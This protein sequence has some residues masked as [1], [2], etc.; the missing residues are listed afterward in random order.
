MDSDQIDG[1]A[2]ALGSTVGGITVAAP[3]L[4][5]GARLAD[6]YT[7]LAVV[8]SVGI[9]AGGISGAVAGYTSSIGLKPMHEGM[10]AAMIGF[11]AGL[12]IWVAINSYQGVLHPADTALVHLFI[13][14]LP[15]TM[16]FPFVLLAG[17][18]LGERALFAK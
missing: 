11:C 15:V 9:A 13:L 7:M 4:L 3:L 18:V 10:I 2:I 5:A 1:R 16:A 14:A 8:S 17:A 6:P 12:S